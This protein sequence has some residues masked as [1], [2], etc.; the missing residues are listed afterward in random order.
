MGPFRYLLFVCGQLGLNTIVRFFYQWIVRYTE[1]GDPTALDPAHAAAFTAATAGVLIL[2]F[3]IFDAVSDPVAGSLS[4]RWV[5][6][7]RERRTLL[8]FSFLIPAVGLALAFSPTPD[9]A[10]ALRWGLL[11]AG[12][13]LF[14]IGYTFY[15]IPYWS[16]VDDYSRGHEPTRRWLSTLLG[17]GLLLGTGV[18]S[19]VSPAVI[20]EHGYLVAAVVFAVPA[21][22]LMTL[23]YFASPRRENADAERPPPPPAMTGVEMLAG[24]AQAFRHKRFIATISVFA[25]AHMALTVVTL[26]A[27]FIVTDLLGGELE[28]VPMVLGP[29]LGTSLLAMVLIPGLT[30]RYGLQRVV[31]VAA[32]LLAIV[33]AGT[34][35]LG[36]SII[37]SPLV[38]ASLLFACGGPMAAVFLSLEGEAV[39]SCAA[40]SGA[41]VTSVYFGVF[42]LV[43][44]GLNAL[45][46][47]I[48]SIL[49]TLASGPL[50]PAAVRLMGVVAGVM[51]VLGIL[52]YFLLPR[53]L[54][55][56]FPGAL[57]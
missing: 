4:D 48:S 18:I 46:M 52:S 12:L 43:V 22:A 23:P 28:D 9:M 2:G 8:W 5:R 29:F 11:S 34:G 56:L 51:L 30:R 32:I 20:D 14:Y 38:T 57:R 26:G 54:E 55:R 47:F 50:G 25:G 44:K 27:P 6:S 1:R 35:T 36:M 17:V 15:A 31:V 45:A 10:V 24:F 7:G 19:L 39:T 16:L 21:A 33:Y 42:N 40:E 49:A 37:G 41:E 3:R 53:A 13:L